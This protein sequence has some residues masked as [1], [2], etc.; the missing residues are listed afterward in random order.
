[1]L[2]YAKCISIHVAAASIFTTKDST[3]SRARI[4]SSLADQLLF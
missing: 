1:M 3:K 4:E 2:L